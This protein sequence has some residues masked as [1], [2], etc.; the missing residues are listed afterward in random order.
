MTQEEIVAKARDLVSPVLGAAKTNK[1]VETVLNLERIKSIGDLR[2][3]L[4][5]S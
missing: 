1:L 3:L 4:Q 5:V 2:P